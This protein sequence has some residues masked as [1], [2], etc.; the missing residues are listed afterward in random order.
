MMT[1]RGGAAVVQTDDT[2]AGSKMCYEQ[3]APLRRKAYA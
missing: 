2:I 3:N 1:P